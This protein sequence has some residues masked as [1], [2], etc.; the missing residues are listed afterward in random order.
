MYL[1]K[2]FSV[3]AIEH[4]WDIALEIINVEEEGMNYL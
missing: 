4:N 3:F 2:E 1:Y